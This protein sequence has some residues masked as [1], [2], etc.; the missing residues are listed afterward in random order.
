VVAD[1]ALVPTK[2]EAVIAVTVIVSSTP[3]PL[4]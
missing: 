1:A 4:V 2:V 3:L